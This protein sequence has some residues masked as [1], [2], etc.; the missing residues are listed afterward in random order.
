MKSIT[1]LSAH[2]PSD[3]FPPTT[4]ALDEPAG[5]LAAGGDLAPQRLLAAYR[6]GIFPWYA[7]GQPVLW[8]SP[9][10]RMVLF[11]DEFHC[12][13]S[14]RKTLRSGKYQCALNRNFAAVIAACAA[15]RPKSEGTW[16]TAEMASAYQEL[17][18]L[19]Y[20]HSVEIYRDQ[21]LCGGLYGVQLG[22]VF[23]GE[24][25]FSQARDTSKMALAHL[26]AHCK[27][28][29][30]GLIDCQMPTAHLVSLGARAIARHEFCTLLQQ[31]IALPRRFMQNS[32]P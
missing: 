18:R 13:R 1:W 24:S 23:F 5:L 15:P 29:Q 3:A 32:R 22:G 31:Q 12:S 4:Q 16:I 14:L 20:A 9:D 26:V 7:P 17:H 10:P 28:V 30:I 21:R 25:M 11:P 2:T 27:S 8:W 6:R 19:G